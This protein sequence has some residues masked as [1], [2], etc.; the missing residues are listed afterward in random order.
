[1]TDPS[2]SSA[3][4]SMPESSVGIVLQRGGEELLVEKVPDRFVISTHAPERLDSV[5]QQL[6]NRAQVK[7]LPTDQAEVVV[8]PAQR[9]AAMQQIRSAQEIKYAGHVY[10]LQDNPGTRVYVT[11]QITVQFAVDVSADAI[12]RLTQPMGLRQLKPVLGIPNTFVFEVTSN[13][14]ENPIKLANRLMQLREVLT[15]EPNIAVRSQDLY[16]PRDPLYPKQWHLNHTGGTDL[17]A[18]SHVFAEKAW[19]ITKGHRAVVVAVADDSVD[20]TH[21]D[22]QGIGKIV[23]PRDFRDLDFLPDPELPDDNHGTSC[24]G[25]AVAEENGAGT[26]GVAPNC[27]LMPLRTSGYLDDESIEDLFNWAI[28]KGAWVVSCSWGASA[29]YFPLSLRQRAAITRATTEGRHGKGCVIV[30]ASGNSNRPV[31][32]RVNERGW[33]NNLFSGNTAW[34]SGFAAHPD[35]IAVSASTSLNKKAAYSNWGNEISVCAPSNNAHPGVGLQA[36]GYVYTAPEIRQPIRGLG[37]VTSDRVGSAGYDASDI[38]S[39][40]GGTSS[41]CPLVAGVAALVLSANPELSAT[42]VRQILQQTADKIV[43][44]DTDPQLGTKKGTYEVGGRSDWF[45]YGKVNAL[46]AVQAAQQRLTRAIPAGRT[47]QQQNTNPVVIPDADLNGVSSAIAIRDNGVLRD[48]QVKVDLSHS[49]LG[50]LTISLV[51]PYGDRVLL[52]GRTLG[53][54][55]NLQTTYTL[56]TT[57]VLRRFLGKPVSGNWQLAIIDHAMGD[58]GTLNTWQIFLGV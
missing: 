20:L 22:F 19:D 7:K 54:K 29:V 44:T 23:A 4:A 1:M 28:E 18:N 57:P 35:V 40:F 16:R 39:D 21:P 15:A 49:F 33:P 41:A 27:S 37:V 43:D 9:D 14:T 47:L 8:N 17:A 53:R 5:V 48:I 52:Q 2:L 50:D 46:R 24:A 13:A 36:V 34:L 51:A 55:I 10:Q 3:N 58:T 38:T 11:D 12:A 30:F 45:G 42:D 6:S 56:Q 31:N 25:V 26:V 32:G